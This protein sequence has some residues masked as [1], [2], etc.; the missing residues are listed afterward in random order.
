MAPNDL[1]EKKDLLG[2]VGWAQTASPEDILCVP[3]DDVLASLKS[4]SSGLTSNQAQ[5]SL[6]TYGY[7]EV[8]KKKR[9]TNVVKFLS[10]FKNPLMLI[11][12]VAGAITAPTDPVEATII[13]I[14]VML[15]V[16]LMYFQESKAEKAA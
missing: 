7:N 10:S 5:E 11:L 8:A 3:I 15:G 1:H 14:I 9:T 6:K 13:F 2:P 12:L 16:F 4:S